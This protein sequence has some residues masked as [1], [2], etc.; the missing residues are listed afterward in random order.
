MHTALAVDVVHS[1]LPLETLRALRLVCRAARD[2]LVDGR[3]TRVNIYS[4]GALRAAAPRLRSLTDL[5]AMQFA[6]FKGDAVADECAAL[7][8]AIERL[9][10]PAAVTS[11]E[12]ARLQPY[13]CNRRRY[14]SAF[15]ALMAAA[16]RLPSVRVLKVEL[17][18]RPTTYDRSDDERFAAVVRAAA[19]MAALE[20]LH[21]D[22]CLEGK[23]NHA[24]FYSK[25][26]RADPALPW[27][28]L[29]CI[30][31][32]GGAAVL[33]PRL[34]EA[35]LTALTSLEA[36][37]FS[38]GAEI[39]EKN[40]EALEALWRAPWVQQLERLTLRGFAPKGV[41]FEKMLAAL[42]APPA[43]PP[44]R[45]LKQLHCGLRGWPLASVNDVRRLLAACNPGELETLALERVTHS[46]VL[47]LAARAGALTALRS[48]AIP[49]DGGAG[50]QSWPWAALHDAPLAPLTRLGLGLWC[51][52][53][54]RDSPNSP[55]SLLSAGWAAEL[56]ELSLVF[57]VDYHWPPVTTQ[58]FATSA[59]AALSQLRSLHLGEPRLGKAALEAA[60][61]EGWAGRLVDF[62]LVQ[63]VM[64]EGA[65]TALAGLPFARL[66]RLRV[67]APYAVADPPTL[68]AFA[69]AGAAWLG[70][71]R[72]LKLS[73]GAH[74][75]AKSL[76]AARALDGP[77]AAVYRSG[78]KVE[79][80]F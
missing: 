52:A 33:L 59:L 69:D 21:L 46:D 30:A 50:E 37:L 49:C 19:R 36:E 56:R 70:R 25:R 48:L 47:G 54:P 10:H 66:E 11:L 78:G 79:A 18:A 38:G 42:P 68:Q 40:A 39:M 8:D 76:A 72:A 9:P 62:T 43:P 61:A 7:A 26:P 24:S 31:L 13:G 73:L 2:E 1:Q 65:L 57:G 22:V 14:L 34:L 12:L 20:E 3:C 67:S 23:V 53:V 5:N 44:L 29:R 35:Q 32:R 28:Q 74:D 64:E 27:G 55:A 45:S 80:R 63:F 71:L 4:F 17:F 41:A 51:D 75:C 58:G 77:F 6:N 60:R 16:G 15:E